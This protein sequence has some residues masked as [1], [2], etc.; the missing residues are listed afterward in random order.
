MRKVSGSSP[1]AATM[2]LTLI[3]VN[4]QQKDQIEAL[5]ESFEKVNLPK[6]LMVNYYIHDNSDKNIGFSRA[7]NL[8]IKKGLEKK[9]DY[10]LLLNP[11]TKINNDFLTN[12]INEV[13]KHTE[14]GITSPIIKFKRNNHWVYDCGGKFNFCLGR[15]YHIEENK[16]PNETFN[17]DYV[18]GCCMLIKKSVIKKIGLFDPNFFLYHEDVDF[19]LRAK[20]HGFIIKS[21]SQSVIEHDLNEKRNRFKKKNLL[22]G[23]WYLIKKHVK[24]FCYP[25][26]LLY[27]FLLLIKILSNE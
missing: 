22:R 17:V 4:Y 25:I 19:C 11:D 26:A 5:V 18:S 13:E 14:I 3:I 10:F 23:N 20:K 21:V 27:Y 7:V 15:P 9:S 2:K 12:L 6:D 24:W 8:G 16:M 1:D